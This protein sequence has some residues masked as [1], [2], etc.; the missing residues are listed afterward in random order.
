MLEQKLQ[1]KQ[2]RK[3]NNDKVSL[4]VALIS[5]PSNLIKICDLV[6]PLVHL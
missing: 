4:T 1:T 6:V 3:P 2:K 5:S